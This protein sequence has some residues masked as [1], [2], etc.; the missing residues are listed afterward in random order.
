MSGTCGTHGYIYIYIYIHTYIFNLPEHCNLSEDIQQS[1]LTVT[2]NCMQ[3][4]HPVRHL[5]LNSITTYWVWLF[6]H[7]VSR[8]HTTAHHSQ[9]D[10]LE[11]WP[12]RPRDLY[13][14]THNTHN[15]QTSVPSVGFES[16][17]PAGERPQTY[18]LDRAVTGTGAHGNMVKVF[19]VLV[20]KLVRRRAI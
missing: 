10:F 14:I 8:L 9:Q 12:A 2:I 13:L 5:L 15:R 16:T 17:T 6:I 19:G 3:E 4:M 20:G 18:A 1:C 11:Q 7:E